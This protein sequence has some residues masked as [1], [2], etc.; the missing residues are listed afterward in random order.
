MFKVIAPYVHF[1]ANILPGP[2][3]YSLEIK[4]VLYYRI[5]TGPE[6]K[7]LVV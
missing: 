3:L 7:F 2:E 5:M 1:L 6:E 4:F